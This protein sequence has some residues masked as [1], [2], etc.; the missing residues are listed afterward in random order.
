[1][2]DE[3][4]PTLYLIRTKVIVNGSEAKDPATAERGM[5][6][7]GTVTYHTLE[8]RGGYVTLPPGEF[9]IEMELSPTKKVNGS[10]RRQFRVLNHGV[11]NSK[12]NLAAILM[13]PGNLPHDVTG[14]IAPGKTQSKAGIGQSTKALEEIFTF[15]GGFGVGKRALLVVDGD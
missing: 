5:L 14:C 13:H 4:T 7:V 12:H 3:E 11:L 9:E 2:A 8:R 1:M 10:P 6:V 15:C